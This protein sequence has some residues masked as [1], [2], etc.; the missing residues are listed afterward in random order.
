MTWSTFRSD[1]EKTV[2]RDRTH[3]TPTVRFTERKGTLA[4]PENSSFR[5]AGECPSPLASLRPRRTDSPPRAAVS[6]PPPGCSLA[7]SLPQLQAPALKL[8]PHSLQA[9]RHPADLAASGH[10]DGRFQV[11][12]GDA[13]RRVLQDQH[14]LHQLLGAD[15]RSY[16]P[17]PRQPP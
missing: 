13:A 7:H 14:R 1:G 9:L 3:I 5:Q 15:D 11:A 8:S 16:N 12:G 2:S 4:T 17:D 10:G 6:L